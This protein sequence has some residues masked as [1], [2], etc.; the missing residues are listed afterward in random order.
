[1]AGLPSV[2]AYKVQPVTAWIA[3]RLI[4]VAHANLVNIILDRPAVP[5]FL[6]E[7]CRPDLLEPAVAALLDD[8]TAAEAPRRAAREEIRN[9]GFGGPPPSA[10]AAAVDRRRVVQGKRVQVSVTLCG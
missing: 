7:N 8:A 10:Q 9:L 5:E 6:Q 4:R 2:I 3:R 1:M